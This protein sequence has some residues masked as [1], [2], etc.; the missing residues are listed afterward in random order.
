MQPPAPEACASIVAERAL[1]ALAIVHH[2]GSVLRHRLADRPA[3][4]QQQIARLDEVSAI[5]LGTPHDQ[6]NGSA[7]AMA[8][9]KPELLDWPSFPVV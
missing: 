4:E 5:P 1:N 3:L 9:G 8:G 2:E 7:A 6:I